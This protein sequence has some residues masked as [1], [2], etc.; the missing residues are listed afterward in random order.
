MAMTHDD[1]YFHLAD[2]YIK[3]EE[4]QIKSIEPQHANLQKPPLAEI[5]GT[6]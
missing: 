1:R 6:F 5:T 2:R 4:G 3:L